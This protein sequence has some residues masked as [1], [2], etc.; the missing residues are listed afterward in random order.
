MCTEP[1]KDEQSDD[2]DGGE[3]IAPRLPERGVVED[4]RAVVRRRAGKSSIM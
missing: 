1:P 3:R 2:E 4:V